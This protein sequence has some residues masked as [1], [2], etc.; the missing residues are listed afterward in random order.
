[1]FLS[2]IIF[3]TGYLQKYQ[4]Y[5]E[6]LHVIYHFIAN[7][8]KK[9]IFWFRSIRH[10]FVIIIKYNSIQGYLHKA[11]MD[12]TPPPSPPFFLF[13]YFEGWISPAI[14]PV[15][16]PGV[17]FVSPCPPSI[18]HGW[19]LYHL[20]LLFSNFSWENPTPSPP[21]IFKDLKILAV[22]KCINASEKCHLYPR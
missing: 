15:D 6:I 9:K 1:M 8:A 4:K 14:S 17:D 2:R 5:L 7:F 13:L 3:S 12:Y 20:L 19:I 18:F 21:S 22:V 16:F 11:K 10:V